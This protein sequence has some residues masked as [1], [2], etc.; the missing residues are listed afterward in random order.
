MLR[1]E[2][3]FAVGAILAHLMQLILKL[4]A[5]VVFATKFHVQEANLSL[6]L[7]VAVLSIIVPAA[8]QDPVAV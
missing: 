3:C 5:M 2:G 6:Y 8:K 1:E 7:V 4:I